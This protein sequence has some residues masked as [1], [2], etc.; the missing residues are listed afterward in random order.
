MSD[1][2]DVIKIVLERLDKI[3]DKFD[4]KLS[5]V[6]DRLGSIDKTLVKQEAQL[7]EHIRRTE[8]LEQ[9]IKPIKK[10]VAYLQAGLKLLGLIALVLGLASTVIKLLGFYD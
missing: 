4:L 6:E 2:S 9:E 10:H 5:K 1:Q 8:L 7:A 3:D